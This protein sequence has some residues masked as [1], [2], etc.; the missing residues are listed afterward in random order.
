M[1]FSEIAAQHSTI[2]TLCLYG[3]ATVAGFA[4]M[5]LRSPGLRRTG[6][7]AAV[8]GLLAQTFAMAL[9][10]HKSLPGGLSMGAY[11]QLIAWFA[12]LCGT[13]SLIKLRRDSLL[14]LSAP[15][16]LALFLMSTPWLGT[17]VKVPDSL[18]AS[19]YALHIGSL[20]LS[21]GLLVL[22]GAAAVLFLFLERRIKAKRPME[23]FWKDMPPIAL[24]DSINAVTTVTAFPLYTIGLMAGLLWAEP[25]FGARVTGDPK[26]IVSLVIWI[27]FAF[28]FHARVARGMKGRK[29]A[30]LTLTILCLCLFSVVVVNTVMHTH[31]AFLRD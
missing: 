14:L 7:V 1:A 17:P 25:L 4:G 15:L 6:C 8:L 5:L 29:P 10:F 13:A 16:G 21:L 18:H 12:L 27:L 2:V 23:G 30:S 9:G 22:A 20:F 3:V 24:L 26:Q 31:H 19:F 28:L 11:L